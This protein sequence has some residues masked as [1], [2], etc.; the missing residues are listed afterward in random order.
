MLRPHVPDAPGK[1]RLAPASTGRVDAGRWLHVLE[2]C[3]LQG[4]KEIRV[5]AVVR[6]HALAGRLC[7]SA[8]KPVLGPLDQIWDEWGVVSDQ[9]DVVPARVVR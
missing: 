1:G 2:S 6:G 7:R 3:G 4:G 9:S 8:V 5:G